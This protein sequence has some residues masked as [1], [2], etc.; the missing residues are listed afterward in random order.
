MSFQVNQHWLNRDDA[1]VIIRGDVR[2]DLTKVEIVKAAAVGPEAGFTYNVN[3]ES[4]R[5]LGPTTTHPLDLVRRI[6]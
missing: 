3:R 4:G 5:F 1:E 2:I 6:D